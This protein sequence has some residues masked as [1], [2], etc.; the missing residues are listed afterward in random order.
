[1]IVL[2]LGFMALVL[3]FIWGLKWFNKM[4]MAK[5]DGQVTVSIWYAL[6]L[7]EKSTDD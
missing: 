2:S 7:A 1:M 5:T 4:H 3:G 6:N